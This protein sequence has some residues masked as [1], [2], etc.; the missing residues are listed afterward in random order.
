[1]SCSH[2][3]SGDDDF[4]P[5]ATW[6]ML[7]QR[8]K[9]L[10]RVRKFFDSRGFTEVETPLLSADTVID[11]HIDPI[12]VTLPDEPHEPTVGRQLWLQSSPEFAMK[13]LLA[14]GADAIY[15][16]T[17]AFRAGERGPLHNVEF[18]ILEWYRI[19]DSYQDGMQLLADFAA[20]LVGRGPPSRMTYRDAF[21]Q[22]ASVDPLSAALTDIHEA[23]RQ[24]SVHAPSG[25][26]ADDRDASLDLLHIHCV[27]PHLGSP[28]PTILFDYPASQAA[29]ARI[30]D[31][32]P[33]VAERFELYVDGIELANGYHELLDPDQLRQRNSRINQLRK[34]DCKSTLPENSHLLA[35]MDHGL[36]PCCGVALGLDRLLM[37]LNGATRIDE[38]VTF[39]IE[40][41]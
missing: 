15:Q 28:H 31:A 4:A 7:R 37:L 6:A 16:V 9:L 3:D 18:T 17:R 8:A 35:A 39:P 26:A 11:L 12:S 24:Q 2:A 10:T 40:R 21:V 27:E 41:A 25:L 13:R 5:T 20:E 33:F 14:V 30:R 34:A 22:Y 23:I 29:L 32:D 19:G 38:V 1:M 36:P